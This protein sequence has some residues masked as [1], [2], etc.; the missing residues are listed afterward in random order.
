M[1]MRGCGGVDGSGLAVDCLF[2]IARC[3]SGGLLWGLKDCEFWNFSRAFMRAAL[4]F[5]FVSFWLLKGR[6]TGVRPGRRLPFWALQ[7]GS[8]ER[9]CRRLSG[10]TRLR[11]CSA[12]LGQVAGNQIFCWGTRDACARVGG[13]VI[14]HRK[15]FLAL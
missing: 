7:K 13:T 12:S 8:K 2:L 4:G 15:L 1:L 6:G 5:L 14:A 3:P 11:A 10:K 9:V